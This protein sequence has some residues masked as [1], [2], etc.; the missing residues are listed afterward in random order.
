MIPRTQAGRDSVA[1]LLSGRLAE[2]IEAMADDAYLVGHPEWLA[3]VEEAKL[4]LHD[5][6]V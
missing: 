5:S 3:I 4:L 1:L 6:E 2:H